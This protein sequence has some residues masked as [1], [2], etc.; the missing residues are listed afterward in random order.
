MPSLL[1]PI[2]TCLFLVFTGILIG[3]VLW[4]RDR[5][6]EE[7]LAQNLNKENSQ[8]SSEL[9]TFQLRNAELDEHLSKQ[10]GKLQILQELCD[11]LVSGRETSNQEK[12]EL[13]AELRSS[14]QLLDLSLIHI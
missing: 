3:Y 1:L 6:E 4:F 13:Q 5:T 8:L 9:S 10:K 11:D 12:M 14:R 2:M 7:M